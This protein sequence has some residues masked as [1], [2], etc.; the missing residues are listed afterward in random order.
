MAARIELDL[1]IGAA[2]TR[3][4]TLQLRPMNNAL[5]DSTI[6]YGAFVT[7][8]LCGFKWS[9]RFI[10]LNI[11]RILSV[12]HSRICG[13]SVPA[14]EELQAGNV[15]VD[16][17]HARQRQRESQLQLASR[18]SLRPRRRHC[19]ARTVSLRQKGPGFSRQSKTHEQIQAASFDNRGFAN[20]GNSLSSNE[21]SSD[22][23]GTYGRGIIVLGRG[24]SPDNFHS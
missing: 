21:W 22:H 9:F 4:Q 8:H 10:L 17:S 12:S 2:F 18:S 5:M 1:R 15:L 14:G 19:H 11:G 20:D 13:R 3:L 23:E 16:Q 24:I 7:R 6:S